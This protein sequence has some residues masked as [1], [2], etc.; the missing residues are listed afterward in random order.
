MNNFKLIIILLGLLIVSCNQK[1]D[2][3][4]VNVTPQETGLG[5][6]NTITETNALNI[7]DYIYFYNG[8]GV[9]I[10]DINNDG[11]AD[12]FLSGNQVKNK[13]YLNKGN[14]QFEDITDKAQVGGNSS[15][16]TGAI[17]GD[18]NGDGLLDIYVCAVVGLNNFIGHNELYINNGNQTFTKSAA[19][20]KLDFQSFGTSAAFLDYDLDGD[21]DLYLLNHAVHTDESYKGVSLRQ[22]RNYKT[23]DKLLRNDGGKFTNVSEKAGI[24]GSISGYGLG[25]A[26]ADFNQDAYPDIYVGN[27]FY[28]DDYYYLNNGDG[29]FSEKL[30][31]F[32]GHASRF[33][34]GNDVADINHDGW[35]DL[36]SLDMLPEDEVVLKSSQG[37]DDVQT[38]NVRKLMFGY[39]YQFTRNMLHINQQNSNYMETALLSGVAATDW[40]WSCLFADYNQDGKQ[41][42]FVTNGI[43]KRPNDLDFTNFFSNEK[44]QNNINNSKLMNQES[45]DAMPSGKVGNYMFKGSKNLEFENVSE[46]WM[47]NEKLVSGATAL[48]D[49]DNDG[50]IDIVVSNINDIVSLYINQTNNKTTNK[51]SY[52]K[53]KFDYKSPNHYGI[54]TKVFTY[55]QGKLQYKELYT[56]RGFQSSSE[57]IMHFGFGAIQNIDSLKI[58]WPNKTSQTIKNVALNQTLTI[59]PSNTKPFDYNSLLN[60]QKKLFK[61]TDNNLGI[62]FTHVEDK[63]LDFNRQKLIPYRVSDRGPAVAVG[64][65]DNDG[66]DDVY[67]G[68]SKQ[69]ASKIFFQTNSTFK[70]NRINIF[71]N[72]SIK[73]DVEALIADFNN[74]A[75]NDIIIGSGGAD[76]SNK[77]KPLLDSYFIQNN[78]G[79]KSETFPEFYENASVII[80]N[81]FDNDNDLDLF[82]GSHAVSS[83][84]GNI[85]N[86]YILENENGTFS[87]VKNDA[88]QKTGMVTDAIWSDFNNDGLVDLILVGEWMAPKFFKNNK[89]VFTE[90]QLIDSK[91]KG[92]WRHI[93]PFDIDND[94][95]TDYLLGN[96]GTN[97]KFK[98]SPDYPMRMYYG[99]FDGNGR[100][101]TIV[102]TY[103]NGAY[104]PLLG[105]NELASQLVK[106][107][108]IFTSYKDF[109]GQPI[110]AILGKNNIEKATILEVN[111]LKSGYLKNENNHFTFV[112]FK[113]ELQVSPISS[114]LSFDFDS[115]GKDEVLAA[116]NY[117][118]VTPFHGKFDSFPGA[119][120]KNE[121]DIVLGNKIGL[122]FSDKAIK[123]LS[124]IHFNKKPYLLTTINNDKVQVYE[125]IK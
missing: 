12:I 88:L 42:I 109:A 115:D 11:L 110:E 87:I 80:A 105:L 58:I 67:F 104:Y 114:F 120:I 54:G 97:S 75:K 90:E 53:I 116:G 22:K 51:T 98:A 72:D 20:Y 17:M 108:K 57:P 46:Q 30:R 60:N 118:G 16:N 48:G 94:G 59:K 69:K 5:F 6:K 15:W 76:F 23:G 102:C 26:V 84:F 49:L 113:N 96:W 45:L 124:I 123:E 64:D 18:V 85:P 4:F 8:G 125:L 121:T 27:D 31:E 14:L 13:L 117:F 71:T 36:M 62:D 50:D 9:A 19:Q 119:L 37:D 70:E 38:Q 100:T 122:D 65:L 78:K 92:L 68:G 89:G 47:P 43:L 10:G 73:E 33:S 79:F 25:V 101:E 86:S 44:I 74:D 111:E 103:K 3:L 32:F 63:Y 34:M 95:D 2:L 55:N 99:D 40:S 1:K 82:I 41:D 52:L 81:D 61:K 29:T 107:H 106:L 83:D 35:P 56:A 112:P 66:K 39:H 24:I 28:E 21:L 93:E 77:T 91:L 7:L